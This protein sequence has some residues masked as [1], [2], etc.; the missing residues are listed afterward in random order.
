MKII[1]LCKVATMSRL[2]A[3]LYAVKTTCN[4]FQFE[5]S[6]SADRLHNVYSAII[7]T[8]T[9]FLFLFGGCSIEN[10]NVPSTH[11]ILFYPYS[12]RVIW[13]D[14]NYQKRKM[15]SLPDSQTADCMATPS[16]SLEVNL[17]L[18]KLVTRTVARREKQ[19]HLSHKH[20]RH[21]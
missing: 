6:S 21:N 15:N 18:P 8:T 14:L 5:V 19:K 7:A 1:V 16:N 4:I 2:S 20:Q 11:E 3:E 9:A 13:L 12:Q 17:S 10:W